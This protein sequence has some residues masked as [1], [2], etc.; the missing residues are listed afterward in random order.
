VAAVVAKGFARIFYR[1]AINL[2]LPVLTCEATDEV[3]NLDR[4]RIDVE[5][6]VIEDVTG[7]GRWEIPPLPEF[8]QAILDAGGIAP[9][10]ASREV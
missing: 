5:A 10:L 9:Y 6:G 1:N 2:G 8:V 3:A 7:L 4:L